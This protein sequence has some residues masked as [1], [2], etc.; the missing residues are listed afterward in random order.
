MT[1]KE[2]EGLATEYLEEALTPSRKLD[3]EAHLKTCPNCQKYVAEMGALIEASHRLGGRLND[4]WQAR[5]AQN[6]EGFFDDLEARAQERPPGLGEWYRKLAPAAVLVV[7]FGI[8]VGLWLYHQSAQ[9]IPVDLTIDLS[10]WEVMRGEEQPVRHPVRLQRACLNATIRLPL[11]QEPG[12]FQVI[13]RRDGRTLV[14]GK[15]E[16]K[17]E[18]YVTTLHVYLDCSHLKSGAYVLAIRKDQSSWQEF[19]GVVP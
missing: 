12:E 8:V 2:I 19:P 17:L 4:S 7:A 16:G 18:N 13:I 1:C 14:Q 3:F 6:Q 9:N 11:G 5:A 10:H 15:S